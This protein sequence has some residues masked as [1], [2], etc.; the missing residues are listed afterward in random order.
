MHTLVPAKA[1]SDVLDSP[2]SILYRGCTV[3]GK[4]IPRLDMEETVGQGEKK[5]IFIPSLKTSSTLSQLSLNSQTSYENMLL[6]ELVM[7]IGVC[8]ID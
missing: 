2:H 8:L 5:S 4:L 7:T 3:L 6:S 1:V